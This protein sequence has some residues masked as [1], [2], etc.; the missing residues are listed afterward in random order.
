MSVLV[1]MISPVAV[2]LAGFRFAVNS[3]GWLM[4]VAPLSVRVLGLAEAAGRQGQAG[5][6]ARECGGCALGEGLIQP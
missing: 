6:V 4:V 1:R 2:R 5:L 3:D